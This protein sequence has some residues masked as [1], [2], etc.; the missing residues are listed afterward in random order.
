ME[1]RPRIRRRARE[2][3]VDDH[4]VVVD[5]EIQR[6][7]ESLGELDGAAARAGDAQPPRMALLVAKHLLDEDPSHGAECIGALGEEQAQLVRNAED[8]LTER[9][10]RWYSGRTQVPP[11]PMEVRPAPAHPLRWP[12]RAKSPGD[13]S[14]AA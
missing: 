2:D 7:A 5:V 10:V 9:Y 14:E 6:T 12:V 8:P 3:S 13:E 11:E 4:D 1:V